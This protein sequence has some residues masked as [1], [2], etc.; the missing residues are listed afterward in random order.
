MKSKKGKIIIHIIIYL[1]VT[2]IGLG[3]LAYIYRTNNF[4]GFEKAIAETSKMTEFKR[5][6]KVKCSNSDSYK[7]KNDDYNDATFYKEISVKPHTP[8]KISCMVKTENVVCENNDKDGGAVIGLLDTTEYSKPISGTNDWQKLEFMFDTKNREKINISFRLGGNQNACTGTVWFSDLKL[9]EGTQ[10]DDTIWKIGCYI[11]QEL[12][13]EIEGEKYNLKTN[14]LDIEKVKENL[15]KFQDDCYNYSNKRME[16]NYEIKEISTPITT[17]SHSDEHGYYVGY[18]NVKDLI[19]DD[20]KKSEYDHIF[21]ICR[22]ENESGTVA[23]PIINNW[24]GLGGMD[25]YGIGYS[26]IRLNKNSNLHNFRMKIFDQTLD[27]VYVHEFLHTLERNMTE[28]G[29]EVPALHDYE[30]YGYLEDAIDGLNQWYKDYMAG[31]I[32]D[33]DTG[34]QVGLNDFVYSTQSPNNSNFIHSTEVDFNKEPQNL[35]EHILTIKQYFYN[36]L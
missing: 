13:V 12:D 5:D 7:I 4:N 31:T 9:E 21:V 32:L 23:I 2:M 6:L 19:Y 24:I 22:M 18:K 20:A 26:L 30:K 27:E 17:I 36:I 25:M 10:R 3:I 34:K 1:I 28:N 35:L 29:Y 14:D 16:V 11:I 33:K 15:E 8:Y